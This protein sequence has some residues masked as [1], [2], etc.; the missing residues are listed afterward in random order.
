MKSSRKISEISQVQTTQNTRTS[1]PDA[2]AQTVETAHSK[3]QAPTPMKKERLKKEDLDKEISKIKNYK[4]ASEERQQVKPAKK[5]SEAQP[6]TDDKN[7][8]NLNSK[9][10]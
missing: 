9:T 8:P 3:S 5:N 1:N 7:R 6:K 2:Q 4:E 10:H